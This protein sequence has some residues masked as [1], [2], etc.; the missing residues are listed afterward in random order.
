MRPFTKVSAGSWVQ[1]AVGIAASAAETEAATMPAVGG[2]DV[3]RL[4]YGALAVD[5]KYSEQSWDMPLM[6]GA[7]MKRRARRVVSV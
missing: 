3:Y 1:L 5:A 4:R 2:N 6:A 7:R